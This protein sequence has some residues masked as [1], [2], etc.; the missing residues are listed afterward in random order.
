MLHKLL[1]IFSTVVVVMACQSK[2]TQQ[3]ETPKT[4]TQLCVGIA[5]LKGIDALAS[6]KLMKDIGNNHLTVSTKSKEAQIWFDQGLNHL[7]GFWHL[8]AYRAFREVI[9]QDS[10]CAMGYWGIAMCAPGFGGNENVWNEAIDKAISLEKAV[11]PF[12]K[13]IIDATAVLVKKGI[14]A[15]QDPFRKLYKAYPNEP[16]AIAFSSI[17]LRQHENETTQQ[18][19]KKLLEDGMKKYPDNAGLMHYYVHV[20]ELRPEFAHAFP[21]ANKMLKTGENSP[22]LTHMPGHLYYLAGDYQKAVD[23]YQHARSQELAYHKAEKIPLSANQNYIHNL[24]FLA[25]AQAELGNYEQT[26]KTA[27]ELAHLML[28]NDIPNNGATQVLLYEGRI[29]PALVAIRYRKW[30]DAESE[31]N[32][33]LH[34]P[35]APIENN[36]VKLYLQAMLAY[37]QGMKNIDETKNAEM[38]IQKGGELTQIMGTFEQNGSQYQNTPEFKVINET[39]DIMSMARYELAGWIDNLDP[40]QPFNDAAWKEA[41]NLQNVIKY[42][43]PPRLMYPIEESLARLHKYRGETAA[44]QKA[45]AAALKRRPKSKMIAKM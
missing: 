9:K 19:V 21:I 37:V 11:T 10:T 4:A 14:A 45:I 6:P 5:S 22:H 31:L 25:I 1:S 3:E 2:A 42:D 17:I 27:K 15:A 33:W 13:A 29:L 16:E 20:M 39:Y 38:A 26:F 36:M 43:E 23:I 44:T 24:Q 28:T 12:E 32:F 41:I 40:K 30:Q 7:H 35:D 18:E 34:T 8:E